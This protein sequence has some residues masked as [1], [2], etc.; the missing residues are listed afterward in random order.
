MQ[1]ALAT[2]REAYHH[3]REHVPIVD[4]LDTAVRDAALVLTASDTWRAV[5]EHEFW[6]RAHDDLQA[7]PDAVSWR[8]T[9]LVQQAVEDD[10]VNLAVVGAVGSGCMATSLGVAAQGARM[11]R[12]A[13]STRVLGPAAGLVTVL[14]SGAVSGAIMRAMMR[15]GTSDEAQGAPALF[16]RDA[17]MRIAVDATTTLGA[18]FALGGRPSAVMPSDLFRPGAYAYRQTPIRT[19]PTYATE[20]EKARLDAMGRSAG[21]HHCGNRSASMYHGDHIPPNVFALKDPRI[22]QHFY[23]QCVAC[24]NKQSA[25]CRSLRRTLVTHATTMRVWKWLP[26]AIPAL[27]IYLESYNC[28]YEPFFRRVQEQTQARFLAGDASVRSMRELEML[29]ARSDQLMADLDDAR[30]DAPSASN[31]AKKAAIKAEIIR[32]RRR[33]GPFR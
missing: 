19:T 32:V 1:D 5:M 25:A 12:L 10:L 2:L 33:M 18:F 15:G 29:R 27:L 9:L 7:A 3:V 24:S 30:R 4:E 13:A 17:A 8:S 31:D 28:V 6:E 26:A 22:V 11:L 23:A 20:S 21:C 16:F 14:A